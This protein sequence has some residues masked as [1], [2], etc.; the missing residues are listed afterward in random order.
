[1]LEQSIWM[2][3]EE[4]KVV[5]EKSV[6]PCADLVILRGSEKL[7]TLL[8]IRKTGYEK[9]KWVLIGGRQYKGETISE[10]I[11][12]QA[13]EV[14]LVVEVIAPF[15]PGFPAWIN[16]D[17]NQDKTKHASSS[18]YP[19]QITFGE[20]KNESSEHSDFNW[21]SLDEL[22][23]MGYQHKSEVIKAIEQ[24]KKLRDIV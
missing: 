14:G 6:I 23:E 18:V 9:G 15:E 3:D 8:F 5:T 24:L 2:S 10:T 22:P 21:F 16:D 17:P 19:V 12:R 7:E 13:N 4:Y 20:V 1:M 11:K